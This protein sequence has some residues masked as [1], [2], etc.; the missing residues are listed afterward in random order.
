MRFHSLI[1]YY[2]NH[3]SKHGE[4]ALIT[5]CNCNVPCQVIMSEY[6][7]VEQIE[8]RPEQEKKELWKYVSKLFPLKTKDEKIIAAKVIHTIGN[9]IG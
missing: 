6:R 5:I 3:V 7:F 1:S 4:S 2:L 9:L 8:N